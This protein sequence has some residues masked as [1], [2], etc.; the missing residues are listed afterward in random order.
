[1]FVVLLFEGFYFFSTDNFSFL[2][3]FLVLYF[4]FDLSHTTQFSG[5]NGFNTTAVVGVN[6]KR[7]QQRNLIAVGDVR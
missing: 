4:I 5:P 6:A 3:F 2:F 1:V 7:H